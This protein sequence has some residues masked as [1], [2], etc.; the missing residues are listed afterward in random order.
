MNV[1][2]V[3]YVEIFSSQMLFI[4]VAR[5]GSLYM[6]SIRAKSLIVK[7]TEE[8]IESRQLILQS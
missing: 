6:P 8:T 3:Q 4:K 5:N 2:N 7:F 1:F